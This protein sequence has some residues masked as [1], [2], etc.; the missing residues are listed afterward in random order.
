M[1]YLD[2]KKFL[3]EKEKSYKMAHSRPGLPKM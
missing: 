1:W 2:P 3:D